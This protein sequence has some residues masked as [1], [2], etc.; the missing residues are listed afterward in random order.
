MIDYQI[1][2]IYFYFIIQ[3]VNQSLNSIILFFH[4]KTYVRNYSI[5]FHRGFLKVISVD[6]KY[7]IV[8]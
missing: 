4:L 2:Y 6:M 7:C 8:R 1:T 5:P 3:H